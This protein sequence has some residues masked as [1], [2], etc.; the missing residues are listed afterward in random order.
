MSPKVGHRQYL[1]HNISQLASSVDVSEVHDVF[2]APIANDM[3]F[4]VDVFRP[5]GRDIVGGH[6]D[7]SLVVFT[8]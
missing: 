7:G 3:V 1:S 8:E 6:A 5:L 2:A 4:D